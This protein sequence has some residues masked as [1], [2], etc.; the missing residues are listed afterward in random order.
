M[1]FKF[2]FNFFL[3]KRRHNNFTIQILRIETDNNIILCLHYLKIELKSKNKRKIGFSSWTLQ[4]SL[5]ESQY[6]CH[7]LSL[8]LLFSPLSCVLRSIHCLLHEMLSFYVNYR[9]IYISSS[10]GSSNTKQKWREY[11]YSISNY[12]DFLTENRL[13]LGV[14]YNILCLHDVLNFWILFYSVYIENC[15]IK[16]WYISV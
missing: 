3:W 6:S 16:I 14:F 2:K 9:T 1:L 10:T 12:V 8:N 7:R 4:S 11:K 15:I 5:C 13:D